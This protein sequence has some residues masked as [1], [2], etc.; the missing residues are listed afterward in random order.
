[1]VDKSLGGANVHAT[2]RLPIVV[3]TGA[4][5]T[6][7]LRWLTG[8]CLNI[9]IMFYFNVRWTNCGPVSLYRRVLTA[10]SVVL[11]DHPADHHRSHGI[12][13]GAGDHARIPAHG[14]IP[15]GVLGAL[16][17]LFLDAVPGDLPGLGRHPVP[18]AHGL[19]FVVRPGL[20]LDVPVH[21][22][23]G[24][25]GHAGRVRHRQD[26]QHHVGR[27]G[28][29]ADFGRLLR[30]RGDHGCAQRRSG[31]PV[32]VPLVRQLHGRR[33]HQPVRLPGPGPRHHYRQ[34]PA[35]V[36]LWLHCHCSGLQRRGAVH[37]RLLPPAATA[38]G[39]SLA[40]LTRCR[41]GGG[42]SEYR[43]PAHRLQR[44]RRRARPGRR[45]RPAQQ[46][47]PGRRRPVAA[48]QPRR[49]VHRAG[50]QRRGQDDD[51]VCDLG[52]AG[53]VVRRDHVHVRRRGHVRA[54]RP[55]RHADRRLPA[56]R[57]HLRRPDRSPAS[58]AVRRPE[59]RVGRRRGGGPGAVRP[60]GPRRPPRWRL[61]RR[62]ETQ[63]HPSHGAAGPPRAGLP[64]RTD[65]VQWAPTPCNQPGSR[66]VWIDTC[67][68]AGGW[69]QS[70]VAA[71]GT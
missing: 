14:R 36:P 45:V 54:R 12:R 51:H 50:A 40:A 39:D 42:R 55:V 16:G 38:T 2:Q 11:I 31:R 19:L 33:H 71:S 25:T 6:W 61:Q 22:G 27:S 10:C 59:G 62:H 21:A 52:R 7:I 70:A 60:G 41:A 35:A 53:A 47:V 57:R 9:G 8:W 32:P 26:R 1:M 68:R 3:S 13:E 46:G 18:G 5:V 48:N 23:P 28:V 49:S 63:G 43:G 29:R 37:H 17:R 44:H 58:D 24:G 20:H 34:R 15:V 30:S 4:S 69:T 67:V 64:R 56:A 65:R 66:R